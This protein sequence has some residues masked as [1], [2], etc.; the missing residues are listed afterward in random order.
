MAEEFFNSEWRKQNETIK[1]PFSNT[2]SL[3]NG[4]GL[5]IFDGVF[6]DA[7]IYLVGGTERIYISQI[8]VSFE[9]VTI[10]IGDQEEKLRASGTFS[11]L[12]LP[13][14]VALKDQY[15]RPAGVLITGASRL[16]VF[17]SWPIGQH[18]FTVNE[19]EFAATACIPTPEVGLRGF[20]LEDGSFFA[21]DV[22]LVGEDGVVLTNSLVSVQQRS[23]ESKLYNTIRVDI[24]GDPLFRRRLCVPVDL[25]SSPR[26]VKQI[27]VIHAD[28]EFFCLPDEFGNIS[29]STS[30]QN[31]LNNP[32]RIRNTGQGVIIEMAGKAI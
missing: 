26:F 23:G 13:E 20:V 7:S 18:E 8:D 4:E 19:T 6:V 14:E 22:W 16:N 9:S 2:A 11:L 24:V 30:N 12:T 29:I 17:Q 1:Y 31:V 27:R 21:G 10:W 3:V 5:T 15:D 32:L 25:F 28:G